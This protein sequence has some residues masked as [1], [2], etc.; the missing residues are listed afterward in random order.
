M[1][2]TLDPDALE[3]LRSALLARGDAPEASAR[4]G[5]LP[6]ERGSAS[7]SALLAR[8]LPYLEL[9][10]LVMRADGQCGENERALLWGAARLLGGDR[11]SRHAFDAALAG[12]DARAPSDVEGRLDEVAA[13]LANDRPGAEA[14][15]A[16]AAAMAVV[17]H[18]VDPR[19]RALLDALADRLGISAE[20]AK[21]LLAHRAR[22]MS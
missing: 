21:A 7:E 17:D 16:L 12:F 4:L 6:P 20:R 11:L 2:W 22:P 1:R 9:L 19:E 3:S 14:A 18:E 8:V 10:Y 5:S 15:F 13:W